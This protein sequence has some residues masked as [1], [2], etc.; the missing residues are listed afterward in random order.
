MYE[1]VLFD[2]DGT[3]TDPAEGITKSVEYA[4]NKWNISVADRKSLFP[5]IG[6]PLIESFME[7]YGFDREKAVTSVSYYREYF[8]KTGLFENEIYPGIKEMLTRLKKAGKRLAVATSKP[9]EFARKI[10]EHFEILEYFDFV[11][12]AAMDET[13]TKKSEVIEYTL[14]KMGVSA[15]DVSRVVMVGDRKHDVEGAACF[16][17]DT[18]GVLYGYGSKEELEKAGAKF[19]A[20]TV[21]VLGTVLLPHGCVLWHEDVH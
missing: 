4:L 1:I 2:L 18:I 20:P 17:I 21:S 19:T 16:G 5:F 6:P 12:G 15:N 7:F 3:L 9:D 14:E 11:G 10:L 13:R 8:A